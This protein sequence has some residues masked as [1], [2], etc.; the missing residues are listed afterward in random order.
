MTL[1]NICQSQGYTMV[2]VSGYRSLEEQA[3]LWRQSRKTSEIK[4]KIKELRDNSCSFLADIIESVG[5]CIG[6]WAT[7]SIPGYS[8]HN[9]S[10][11]VDFEWKQEGK[12]NGDG[13]AMAYKVL[14]DEAIKL[15]L[16]SGYYFS[17]HKD[18][19][20][21]QLPDKEVSHSYTLQEVNN[22]FEGLN[23]KK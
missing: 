10:Q 5:P 3:K 9:W 11:A 14:A 22:Y 23:K 6:P 20:H 19:G 8:W 12:I 21:I 7:N 18:A 2:P 17:S 15:G 13:D 4:T 1:L 16:T